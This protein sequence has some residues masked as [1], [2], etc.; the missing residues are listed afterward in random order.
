[1]GDLS[2]LQGSIHPDWCEVDC[3]H[4]HLALFVSQ[5]FELL[6]KLRWHAHDMSCAPGTGCCKAGFK[7]LGCWQSAA[8]ELCGVSF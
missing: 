8:K 5:T 2:Q 7:Q 6:S 4:A 3:V 1:M